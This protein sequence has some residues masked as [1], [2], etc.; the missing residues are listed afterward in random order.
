[1]SVRVKPRLLKRITWESDFFWKKNRHYLSFLHPWRKFYTLH[2]AT[3]LVLS[4]SILVTLFDKQFE[5][6]EMVELAYEISLI[7]DFWWH[8]QYC[9]NCIARYFEKHC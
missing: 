3:S 8:F 5:S 2:A 4:V 7:L 1:M 9:T 6:I